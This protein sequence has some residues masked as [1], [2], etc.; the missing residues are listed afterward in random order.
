MCVK[1]AFNYKAGN[2]L[3]WDFWQG[4]IGGQ[5]QK[6]QNKMEWQKKKPEMAEKKRTEWLKCWQGFQVTMSENVRAT[7]KPAKSVR[8]NWKYARLL[9]HKYTPILRHSVP[10]PP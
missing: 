3:E 9:Y 4:Q 2:G 6:V 5:E 7:I 10:E 8:S 1:V